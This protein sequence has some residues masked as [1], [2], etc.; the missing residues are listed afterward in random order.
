MGRIEFNDI[1][2]DGIDIDKLTEYYKKRKKQE[3]EEKEEEKKKIKDKTIIKAR[4]DAAIAIKLYLNALDVD[5]IENLSVQEIEENLKDLEKLN[6]LKSSNKNYNH[7]MYS[8]TKEGDKDWNFDFEGDFTAQE[9]KE[10]AER[11]R[12]WFA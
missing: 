11:L 9:K 8:A 4:K 6:N 3:E 10:I 12:K 7:R 5:G 2:E 1:Y